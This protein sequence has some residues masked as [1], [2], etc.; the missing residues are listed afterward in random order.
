[1]T[2]TQI[3]DDPH[4][5]RTRHLGRVAA[6]LSRVGGLQLWFLPVCILTR[7]LPPVNSPQGW[8][9]G[10]QG[11]SIMCDPAARWQSGPSHANAHPHR[12]H[13]T[14]ARLHFPHGASIPRAFKTTTLQG[15][16]ALPSRV[17]TWPQWHRDLMLSCAGYRR[18]GL[19]HM[20]P[21]AHSAPRTLPYPLGWRSGFH[22]G[23]L[24]WGT[25]AWATVT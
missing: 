24:R 16:R 18:N 9:W 19:A 1:M 21:S 10:Q 12:L 8:S 5:G 23:R 13:T 7:A 3:G 2:D 15:Y 6:V 17:L 20:G 11:S 4:S 25:A 14:C 22:T